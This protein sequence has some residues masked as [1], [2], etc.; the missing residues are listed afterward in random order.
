MYLWT[1]YIAILPQEL[2]PPAP[3]MYGF[4]VYT[5]LADFP[6]HISHP[7][8]ALHPIPKDLECLFIG[9]CLD[10]RRYLMFNKK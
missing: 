3:L 5:E 8:I 9:L 6:I 2:I 10:I 4:L 1:P 7:V